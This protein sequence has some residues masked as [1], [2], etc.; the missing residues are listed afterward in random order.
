MFFGLAVS[1]LSLHVVSSSGYSN[2][3]EL[4]KFHKKLIQLNSSKF[5]SD[6]QQFFSFREFGALF[7]LNFQSTSILF[8]SLI[9][10]QA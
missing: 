5:L 9:C 2:A 4:I 10:I 1:L 6:K 7:S 3:F 8:R